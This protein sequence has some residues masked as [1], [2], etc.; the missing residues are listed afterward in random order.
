MDFDFISDENFRASLI[1][2]YQELK[3]CHEA[4]SLKATHVLAGSIIE[5]LLIEYLVVTK[6]SV[7]NKDVLKLDL[8]EAI[9]ACVNAGV[10]RQSTSSLCDVIR[11]YRNLIH[12]GRMVRLKGEVTQ[13][14]ANI[15]LNI[16]S[17]VTKEVSKKRKETLG[18]T[19]KQIANKLRSDKHSLAVLPELIIATNEHELF[20]LVDTTIPEAFSEER[21]ALFGD[22]ETPARL[23]AA[24]RHT[25]E[26]LPGE[27][28][29][30][31]AEKFANMVRVESG[32]QIQ[33]FGDAFF[34]ASDI[35]HL[36]P[37]DATLVTKYLLKRLEGSVGT[38]QNMFL[39]LIDI[40]Q[41]VSD[42]DFPNFIDM[43]TRWLLKQP[44]NFSDKALLFLELVFNNVSEI[45]QEMMSDRVGVLRITAKDKNYPPQA[46]ERIGE[47]SSKWLYIPF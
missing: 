24:Y 30:R 43:L 13:E 23:R 14:G 1:S 39:P 9:L 38:G 35:I 6:T 12:P 46:Q 11:D 22:G 36:K 26:A 8:S 28:Q 33:D 34:T 27:L 3:A 40:G 42:A 18:P 15:A 29:K 10:I 5:A 32:D 2:D 7:A 16:V 21:A 37:A 47:L 44:P 41:F 31:I 4:G 25:L 19:A 17:I 45:R 20:K